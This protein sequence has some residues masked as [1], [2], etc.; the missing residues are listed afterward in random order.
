MTAQS[1]TAGDVTKSMINAFKVAPAVLLLGYIACSGGDKPVDPL[2]ATTIVAFSSTT[3]TGV[4][5]AATTPAP[6]VL[7][8]DQNG[9]PLAG[10]VV[11]FLVLSGGGSVSAA[12]A[13]TSASGVATVNW[14]LG[15]AVGAN[16]LNASVGTLTAVTFTATSTAGAASSVA[17]TAGDNQTG[18]EGHVVSVAPSITVKDANG[19]PTAAVPVTF[20]VATGGGSVTGGTTTTNT[21][22]IATVGSW[23]LG[24]A[25]TNTLTATAQGLPAV[26]FTAT[27]QPNLCSVTTPHTFGG[28]TNGALATTDCQL[29]DGTFIDFYSVVLPQADAYIFRQTASFDTYMYLDAADGT[30]IAEND[31]E[32]D[33]VT[34]SAIKALLPP[35]TYVIGANSFDANVFGNYSVSS[36]TTPT[37]VGNCEVVFAVKGISTNQNIEPTDCPWPSTSPTMYADI[38]YIFLKT[39]QQLTITMSSATIDSGLE[40]FRLDNPATRVGVNEDKD[41]TTKDAQIVY[42]ATATNYYAIV[43]RTGVNLQTGAYTLQIQ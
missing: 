32:N 22:G 14:T 42:T 3:L 13:T 28:T 16:A 40:L 5:G 35:G 10:A 20:A 25:G 8:K 43:A 9:A 26:T 1:I 12:S 36:S 11:N 38:Y 6:S 17:K 33:N 31:D 15:A 4:A 37:N 41:A 2:V 18:S 24:S 23:T 39:G 34:N 19:N 21:L 30:P 29:S 27:A 7:V